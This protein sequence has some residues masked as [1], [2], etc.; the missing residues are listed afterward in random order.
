LNQIVIRKPSLH[1]FRSIRRLND[2]N[3]W[4][5]W[6]ICVVVL[7]I[8]IAAGLWPF[9]FRAGNKV[10]WLTS[11]NGVHF[12][13]QGIIVGAD[14]R[15]RGQKPPFSEKSITLELWLRP[16]QET[17]NL[18]QILTLYDGRSPEPLF[19]GQWKSH[20]VIR[21]RREEQVARVKEKSYREIGLQNGLIKNRDTFITITSGTG[22]TSVYVNGKSAQSYSN[23]NM[24]A[25]VTERPLRFILGNSP[26]G[27]SFWIG[28]LLGFAVYNRVLNATEVSKSHQAWT[29]EVPAVVSA[30]AGCVGMYLFDE[31]QGSTI[32]NKADSGGEL[33]IP[34]VFEPVQRKYLASFQQSFRWSFS[35]LQ[36]ITINVIG[37]IP[38]GFFFCALL[39][40]LTCMG[41]LS[42][43]AVVFILGVV[44]SVAIEVSQA[45]LPTR[46]SSSTDV[47][48]N[49]LGT[50]LGIVMYQIHK[51]SD[52]RMKTGF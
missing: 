21:S 34:E 30:D 9:N 27:E 25:D 40:K 11:Q 7:V 48:M 14:I 29:G 6:A 38:F 3:P 22:G 17:T 37:F 26:T 5:L 15:N 4:L 32:H 43:S 28:N 46:D 2:G 10:A 50:I 47:A 35:Y 20:L 44:L 12:F 52:T 31:R 16:L 36:D 19:V 51:K 24:L 41:R 33:V 8:L 1:R 49:S 13:G 23:Y 18:P 45:Y 39:L 42:T